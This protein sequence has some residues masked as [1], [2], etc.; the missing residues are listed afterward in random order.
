MA[1]PKNIKRVLLGACATALL[2]AC[3]EPSPR[4]PAIE[5]PSPLPGA[6][7]GKYYS[8]DLKAREG[9]PPLSWTGYPPAGFRLEPGSGQLSG[10]AE[11]AG[12][13]CFNAT[14][15]DRAGRSDT[16][17]FDLRITLDPALIIS[18]ERM[19]P[20]ATVGQRYS[21]KMEAMGASGSLNWSSSNL[22]D[23]FSLDPST[24]LMQGSPERPGS[25]TFDVKVSDSA[26]QCATKRLVLAVSPPP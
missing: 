9:K 13:F 24:G 26:N 19:L 21:Q 23:D 12:S 20:K 15:Q 4:P 6:L 22:S 17:L 1:S 18:I 14:V 2:S 3:S 25:F 16:K 10:K 7:V 8:V 11:R 5:T